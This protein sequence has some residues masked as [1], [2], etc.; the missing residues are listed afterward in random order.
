M[1]PVGGVC[2]GL[3]KSKEDV[4][5]R[6]QPETCSK[7]M[8]GGWHFPWHMW[9]I[10]VSRSR[11]SRFQAHSAYLDSQAGTKLRCFDP[12]CASNPG[13]HVFAGCSLTK[14]ITTLKVVQNNCLLIK[15]HKLSRLL[16]LV[17]WHISAVNKGSPLHPTAFLHFFL[18]PLDM[19]SL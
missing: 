19:L 2:D 13:N 8:A 4:T 15:S 7:F 14:S 9:H 3:T 17:S 12:Y 10:C 18:A 6:D 5:K 11:D 1:S 16:I